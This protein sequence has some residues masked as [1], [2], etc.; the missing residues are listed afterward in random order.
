[1]PVVQFFQQCH[2]LTPSPLSPPQQ[3]HVPAVSRRRRRQGELHP[4]C[5]PSAGI[6]R[7]YGRLRVRLRV[8]SR[9]GEETPDVDTIVTGGTARLGQ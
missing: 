2:I 6:A 7:V 9:D 1:M 3:V 5:M 8:H 4:D